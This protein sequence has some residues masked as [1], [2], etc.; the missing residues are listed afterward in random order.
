[1]NKK[2]RAKKG[3]T[4]IEILISITILVILMIPISSIIMSSMN[5]N[6]QSEKVQEASSKGQSIIEEFS[7]YDSMSLTK[8][9][10]AAGNEMFN[11]AG[12]N[13]Y[14]YTM[15]DGKT[16]KFVNTSN[17]GE[18]E[19]YLSDVNTIG[20]YKYRMELKQD[21]KGL[22][23]NQTNVDDSSFTNYYATI[24]FTGS[25]KFKIYNC[26]DISNNGEEAKTK[27]IG[28]YSYT[29]DEIDIWIDVS[30]STHG[31]ERM[32]ISDSSDN[33]LFSTVDKSL[34]P[35][36]NKYED[37]KSDIEKANISRRIKILADKYTGITDLNVNIYCRGNLGLTDEEKKEGN[38]ILKNI[39]ADVYNDN[40]NY[41][42]GKS[43]SQKGKKTVLATCV[44]DK[45][46]TTV[47]K[48]NNRYEEVVNVRQ[49]K[50]SQNAE[51]L[52]D[53]YTMTIYV[54]DK[55]SSDDDINNNR[56]K[57]LFKG[58]L[59]HNISVNES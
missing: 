20:K 51:V 2:H 12:K 25:N 40:Y 54:Y 30:S 4:L 24:E 27:E 26:E 16:F 13:I 36:T 5:K 29:G 33:K 42:D 57:H 46:P 39:T 38:G 14:Q 34:E 43:V 37:G 31:I 11:P 48:S 17:A 53:L 7:A 8:L 1:M 28:E 23:K 6:K 35:L 18:K 22:Y 9:K 10:D 45:I 59:T 41:S 56:A 55:N 49:N 15:L 19:T 50:S 58:A 44:Y 52:D 32:I 47:D 3:F 21:S